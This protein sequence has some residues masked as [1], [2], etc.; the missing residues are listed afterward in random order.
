MVEMS[1]SNPVS[2]VDSTNQE[3]WLAWEE[4]DRLALVRETDKYYLPKV[5]VM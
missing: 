3:Q 5:L 1:Q 4:I 2:R